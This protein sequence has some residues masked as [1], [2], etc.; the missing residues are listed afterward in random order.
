[1]RRPTHQPEPCCPFIDRD[2]A[3]CD[4]RFTLSRLREAFSYCF[5]SY[6]SCPVYHQLMREQRRE[7]DPTPGS[8]GTP[9]PGNAGAASGHDLEDF[10]EPTAEPALQ[11]ITVRGRSLDRF[12]EHQRPR[13]AAVAVRAGSG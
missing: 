13:E 5:D 6:Q 10:P 4:E 7:H 2:D 12:V 3:R 8:P 11:S 9:A 1:M